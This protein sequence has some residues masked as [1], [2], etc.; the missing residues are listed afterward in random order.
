MKAFVIG[1]LALIAP[2]AAMAAGGSCQSTAGVRK[3]DELV[4]QCKAISK[5]DASA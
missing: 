3:V 4:R 1:V 5:A 2:G